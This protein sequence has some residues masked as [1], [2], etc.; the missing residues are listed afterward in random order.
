[1]YKMLLILTTVFCGLLTIERIC[2]QFHK[3]YKKRKKPKK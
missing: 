3:H 2:E 1:M